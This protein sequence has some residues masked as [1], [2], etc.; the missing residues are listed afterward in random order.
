MW[1]LNFFLILVSL[2]F[3]HGFDIQTPISKQLVREEHHTNVEKEDFIETK[4]TD[5]RDVQREQSKEGIYDHRTLCLLQSEDFF[6]AKRD[7]R[8]NFRGTDEC[9]LI[10]RGNETLIKKPTQYQWGLHF[11]TIYFNITSN[12]IYIL[13]LNL[14][15]FNEKYNTYELDIKTSHKKRGILT[16]FEL[17]TNMYQTVQTIISFRKG[18][19]F[20]VNS[21]TRGMSFEKTKM[22][23]FKLHPL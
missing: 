18:Q 22:K 15:A 21:E 1:V 7:T 17:L 16:R 12:G 14:R 10:S 5:Y 11:N 13:E 2:K 23:I 4:T 6:Y 20:F 3:A 8:L 9:A 19:I